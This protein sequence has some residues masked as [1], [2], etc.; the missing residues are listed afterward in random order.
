MKRIQFYIQFHVI[1]LGA[2]LSA[3]KGGHRT[4]AQ[5]AAEF[6]KGQS[7]NPFGRPPLSP[8]LARITKLTKDEINALFAKYSRM[9]K[10]EMTAALQDSKLPSLEL[11]I[12]SGIVNGIRTGDWYNLNLMLDRIFGKPKIDEEMQAENRPRIVIM[13]PQNGK[14]APGFSAALPETVDAEVKKESEG[15]WTETDAKKNL[16]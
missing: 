8:H 7:G 1:N 4:E 2:V 14:E 5:K 10:E 6:K 3:K 16:N 11:W 15:R 13:L 12:A 9:S